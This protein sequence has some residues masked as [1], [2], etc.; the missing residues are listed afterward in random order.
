MNILRQQ[1]LSSIIIII[2]NWSARFQ[3][4]PDL[5]VMHVMICRV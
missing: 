2:I 1:C 4:W 3:A 5:N